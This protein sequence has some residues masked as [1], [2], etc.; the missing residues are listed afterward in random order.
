MPD[1]AER[2]WRICKG[3]ADDPNTDP[4]RPW[5][6]WRGPALYG[7]HRTHGRCVAAMT[8]SV[9]RGRAAAADRLMFGGPGAPQMFAGPLTLQAR[10]VPAA[11]RFVVYQPP[12][13]GPDGPVPLH[14]R[15][16]VGIVEA[17]C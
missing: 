12:F 17:P 2:R 5:Q 1:S 6:L 15:A 9:A 13:D 16:V 10:E 8:A 3:A 4:V 7:E 14:R 11:D